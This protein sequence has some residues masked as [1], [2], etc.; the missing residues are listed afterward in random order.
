MSEELRRLGDDY[1]EA[2]LRHAPTYATYLGDHRYHDRL[3]DLSDAGRAEWRSDAEGFLAR[4]RGIDRAGLAEGDRV[5]LEIL[6][7]QLEN[8]LE[9]QR[10]RF[11]TWA[12]DQMMGPQ[13]DFPQLMNFHP[14]A[15]VA[16]LE[17]R[18]RAFPTY[19]A[20]Y[21]DNLRA[22]VA[23]GR[24]AIRPAVER[25]VGQ[26]KA[27]LATP[28]EKSPFAVAP[29]LLPAIRDAI[30]PAFA[31]MLATL[32]GEYLARARSERLG[33]GALPGG[34]EAYRFCIRQHT[35]TALAADEIHRI[36]REEVE[37]IRGEMRAIAKGDV[38]AFMAKL[39]ADPANFFR[40]REELLE[41]ARSDYALCR[42]ALPRA[43]SRLPRTECE[44][45]AIE[46]YRER[47]AVGA[48]Y[49]APDEKLTRKGIYY[50]NTFAPERRPRFNL[51]ALTA[52]EAVPGHHLQ[53]ALA[54]EIEGLPRF[55]RQASF[56]AF[57]EGWAL[58]TERLAD[59]LGL[60][61]DDLQRFGM[62]TYQAWRA[63]RLVVDTG[64]HALGWTREQA[65]RY[66]L[67][68]VAL[69]ETEVLNEV[70][71]YLIWPGQALAYMIGKR[72]IWT[73]REEARRALGPR[74]DLKAFH[75]V[76]LRNGAL[77]LSTLRA[78]VRA[79]SSATPR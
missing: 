4:A 27:L 74:F 68:T 77:P 9:E 76:V 73:L 78:V 24:V 64:L 21:L 28:P 72:E 52:H 45:K 42:A 50:A 70:D 31:S 10:H 38:G 14:A 48:F 20:Q 12:V 43:F 29:S 8:S 1:W 44:V 67:D 5:T 54:M 19:L 23:E 75:D 56:T 61:E 57:V 60:Y 69:S 47:D 36:G 62:L 13:S 63:A 18:F 11:F 53:I 41:A 37:G 26:L 71:R 17:A 65:I 55:R 7:L 35:T 3:A 49:Y 58:Y 30:Y 33:L 15:D 32:E 34:E 6:E 79:W 59:E 16:G 46:E 2:V 40:T 66:F 39:K 51:R 22:G 25:V